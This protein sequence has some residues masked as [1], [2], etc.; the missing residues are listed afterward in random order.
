MQAA[1]EWL[2]IVPWGLHKLLNYIAKKYDNPAIYVTENGK[3]S[4]LTKI[5]IK[6]RGISYT[7]GR[8]SI[9]MDL[10]GILVMNELAKEQEFRA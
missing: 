7:G 1:S 5:K 6:E 10:F 2:F 3:A 8:Y 4:I 9:G